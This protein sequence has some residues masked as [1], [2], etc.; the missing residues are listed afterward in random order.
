MGRKSV[1][2]SLSFGR[3]G[4]CAEFALENG[5]VANSLTRRTQRTRSRGG[6]HLSS[7]PTSNPRHGHCIVLGTRINYNVISVDNNARGACEVLC[8]L[9]GLCV[10]RVKKTDTLTVADCVQGNGAPVGRVQKRVSGQFFDAEDA[11]NAEPRRKKR[12]IAV[13]TWNP[14]H[15]HCIVLGTR[16]NCNAISGQ[17]MHVL[18]VKSSAVSA[19][20]ASSASKKPIL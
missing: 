4:R 7:V 10:L 6:Q 16:I 8:G 5:L 1:R 12:V 9:C 15:G 14:R 20:S 13:L 17:T 2:F 19:S 3:S 11:E 18:L